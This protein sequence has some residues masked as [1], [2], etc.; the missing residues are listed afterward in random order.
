MVFLHESVIGAWGQ[1]KALWRQNWHNF[2]MPNNKFADICNMWLHT[3]VW[4]HWNRKGNGM[5]KENFA[6]LNCSWL[7]LLAYITIFM[8]FT[9][10]LRSASWHAAN[11]RPNP[12]NIW[13]NSTE[14]FVKLY[15]HFHTLNK[16]K[17][18]IVC[19]ISGWVKRRLNTAA[20]S[21]YVS[22]H[23]IPESQRKITRS[24]WLEPH[25]LQ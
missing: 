1:G 15:R 24:K 10:C 5:H 9:A 20:I 2:I 14:R 6:K 11:H 19:G 21:I 4:E 17:S 23:F 22:F 13:A 3:W 8:F 25:L 7:A 12:A 18:R 16:S